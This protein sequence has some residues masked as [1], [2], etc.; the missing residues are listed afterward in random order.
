MDP[1][2]SLI[3]LE[4]RKALPPAGKLTAI[5]LR[6]LY[7]RDTVLDLLARV[8]CNIT[9]NAGLSSCC[10]VLHYSAFSIFRVPVFRGSVSSEPIRRSRHTQLTVQHKMDYIFRLEQSMRPI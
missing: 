2:G 1:K 4:E 8:H 10:P 3:P 9:K 6:P 5:F 7:R